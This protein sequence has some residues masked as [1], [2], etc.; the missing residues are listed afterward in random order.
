MIALGILLASAAASPS[1]QVHVDSPPNTRLTVS[2][3]LDNGGLRSC[4]GPCVLA[5]PVGTYSFEVA[6]MGRAP[7]G[8]K[9]YAIESET[10]VVVKPGNTLCR[11][12]FTATVAVGAASFVTGLFGVALH[13]P[14]FPNSEPA[15]G[16]IHW[17]WPTLIGVG[18]VA[19][20]VGIIGWV[21]NRTRIVVAAPPQSAQS[22]AVWA[23]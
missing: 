17:V 19:I 16:R 9:T 2:G 1:V 12:L 23:F 21:A 7:R 15:E 8:F 13:Y 10:Y 5:L 14:I 11:D 6:A 4:N 3:Y 18:A 20:T 22:A